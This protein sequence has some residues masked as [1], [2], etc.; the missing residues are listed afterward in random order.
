MIQKG[1]YPHKYMNSWEK[2]EQIKLPLTN[3]FYSKLNMKGISN[4]IHKYVQ[5]FS[6]TMEKAPRLL[7]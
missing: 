5:Q 7:S 1:A 3:A 6:N 2:F 4:N